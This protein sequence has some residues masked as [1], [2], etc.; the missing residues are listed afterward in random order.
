MDAL[1]LLIFI[2]IAGVIVW[3][4]NAYAPMQP[5]IKNIFNIV[6]V[7]VV[8]L[9]VLNAFGVFDYFRGVSVPKLHK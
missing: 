9:V 2:V 6:A 7:I 8:A 1:S 5:T 3:A 4:V